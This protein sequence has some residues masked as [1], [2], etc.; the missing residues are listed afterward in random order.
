MSTP[1]I[2][3]LVGNDII[4]PNDQTLY[5]QKYD[6]PGCIIFPSYF[7]PKKACTFSV[8]S[9]SGGLY[10]INNSNVIFDG[11]RFI[12]P[13]KLCK[14]SVI[15]NGTWKLCCDDGSLEKTNVIIEWSK[16]F[17]NK[18]TG[19]PPLASRKYAIFINGI[20]NAL[21]HFTDLFDQAVANEASNILYGLYNTGSTSSVYD[22]FPKLESSDLAL[23]N[24]FVTNFKN[25][26]PIPT[27]ATNPEAKIPS[28]E[29]KKWYGTNPALPNWNDTTISYLSNTYNTMADEPFTDMPADAKELQAITRTPNTDQIAY[30]FANTA[31]PAHLIHIACSMIANRDLSS[32]SCAKLLALLSIAIA[33]A[34][35]YAW[36]IKYTYWGAR[37]FQYISGYSPLITTPNFP[38]YIS[39]HSTFSAAWDQILG[40]MLPSHK[41]MSKYIAD[42][43]GISRLYG[44]IHFSKDNV[45]GLNSGRAIAK[46]VYKNLLAKIKNNEAFL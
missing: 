4:V 42:L 19:A 1:N 3:N 10:I 18:V 45:I 8:Q 6:T 12:I 38:G 16:L 34:G 37:P 40:M 31:P 43:S 33:D 25:S 28:P 20:Y 11:N 9:G 29:Q 26:Y 41:D 5:L 22:K 13:N 2:K 35:I 23:V 15:Q 17:Y 7:N 21:L 27:S 39:G 32:I 14:F 24:T 44:G 36:K 46:S 30:H